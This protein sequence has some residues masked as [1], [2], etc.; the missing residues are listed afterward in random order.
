MARAV[1]HAADRTAHVPVAT[2]QNVS[3]ALKR[4]APR[5]R[6]FVQSAQALAAQGLLPR[7]VVA[8]LGR[9][10][11]LA[12]ALEDAATVA[13]L[14]TV[15]AARIEGKH[16]FTRDEVE[17]LARDAQWL[18]ESTLPEGARRPAPRRPGSECADRD[19]LWT[20]LVGR[21]LLLQRLGGYLYGFACELHVPPLR[22]R[23]GASLPPEDEDPS[24][25][26]R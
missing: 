2:P 18:Q 1:V 20:L 9:R 17:A 21:H 22:G 24:S 4:V 5:R 8:G 15:H 14:F 19:R 12:P 13:R 11:G 26:T 3:A 25:P 7:E 16:P 23:A 10:R 6:A